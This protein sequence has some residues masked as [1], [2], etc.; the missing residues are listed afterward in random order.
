MSEFRDAIADA[1]AN[2]EAIDPDT[3][4][5]FP[6]DAEDC[7]DAILA[8]PEMQAMKRAFGADADVHASF[9]ELSARQWLHHVVGLPESVI[10]WVLS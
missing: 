4:Q 2:A 10:E 1:V 3:Q 8:M 5:T 9:S 7:A 6:A